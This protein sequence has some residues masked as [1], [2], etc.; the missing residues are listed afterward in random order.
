MQSSCSRTLPLVTTAS[1]SLQKSS[2][3]STSLQKSSTA[4]TSLQETAVTSSYGRYAIDKGRTHSICIIVLSIRNSK[5]GF[6][7]FDI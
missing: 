4:S 6:C 1:T 3:A 2:T 5:I 7:L